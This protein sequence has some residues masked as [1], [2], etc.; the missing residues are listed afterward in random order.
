VVTLTNPMLLMA[1]LA[2]Q[3][4]FLWGVA[5]LLFAIGEWRRGR[6]RSAVTLA[7]LAQFTHVAVIGPLTLVI[8]VVAWFWEPDRRALV[9]GYAVSLLGAVPGVLMMLATPLVSDTTF[10]TK[11]TALLETVG[12]RGLVIAGPAVVA[13]L[14]ARRFSWRWP[15]GVTIGALALAV[16]VSGPMQLDKAVRALTRRPDPQMAAFVATPVFTTTGT[17]RYLRRDDAKVGMYQLLRA[18]ARLDSEFFPESMHRVQFPSRVSYEAFVRERGIT[19]VVAFTSA[20]TRVP[21]VEV[22]LLA[23]LSTGPCSP[24][25]I[26]VRE[27][28]RTASYVVY[29]IDPTPQHC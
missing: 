18:G 22:A 6:I 11:V 8:V 13:L 27:V 7:A 2:G 4:P 28:A 9:V 21:T 10:G 15:V 26:G 25:G 20:A 23:L 1:P 24:G 14:A 16:A 29:D 5:P 3:V 17:Y 19:H 12:A